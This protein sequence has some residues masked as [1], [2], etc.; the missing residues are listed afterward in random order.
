MGE[1]V[2]KWLHLKVILKIWEISL[3]NMKREKRMSLKFRAMTGPED[4]IK[5]SQK[6]RALTLLPNSVL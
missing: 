2:K 1:D 3:K 5:R 6:R 4:R